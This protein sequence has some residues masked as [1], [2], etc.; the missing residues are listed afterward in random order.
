MG[1][2]DDCYQFDIGVLQKTKWDYADNIFFFLFLDIFFGGDVMTKR[3]CFEDKILNIFFLILELNEF[4]MK[5]YL[6]KGEVVPEMMN[7]K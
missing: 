2:K 7:L 5:L 3:G 1:H 6:R 4:S